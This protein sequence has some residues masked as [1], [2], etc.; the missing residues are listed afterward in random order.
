MSDFVV[1]EDSPLAEY[2]N[3]TY[4]KHWRFYTNLPIAI[5]SGESL[6]KPAPL[7][8]GSHPGDMKP[9]VPFITQL[10]AVFHRHWRQSLFHVSF[11]DE[12]LSPTQSSSVFLTG[13]L[14]S[15]SSHHG[16]NSV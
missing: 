5:D 8:L 2:L 16:G 13:Y 3:C 6:I 15:L 12:T 11:I 10:S 9:K 14:L 7:S 1:Y 4:N